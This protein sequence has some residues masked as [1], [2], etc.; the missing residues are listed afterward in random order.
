MFNFFTKF[1]EFM[2]FLTIK[3]QDFI[4]FKLINI[5]N[6]FDSIFNIQK[7]LVNYS[8]NIIDTFFSCINL[9]INFWNFVTKLHLLNIYLLIP[10]T[11]HYIFIH[12]NFYQKMR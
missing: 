8:T 4:I 5:F 7:Y 9:R 3:T 12:F 10:K 11:Y 2:I 6:L 1:N